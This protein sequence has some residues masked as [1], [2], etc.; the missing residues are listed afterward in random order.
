MIPSHPYQPYYCEENIRC[1]IDHPDFS[2]LETRVIFMTNRNRTCAV[3]CMKLAPPGELVIWDYHCIL[4]TLGDSPLIFDSD[5]R[6]GFGVP[7]DS[8]LAASFPLTG[9]ADLLPR[10]R[11]LEGA[12]YRAHFASDRSHMRTADGLWLQPPPPW[13]PFSSAGAS[14]LDRFLD[15]DDAFLGTVTD[16]DGLT[17]LLGG[18]NRSR[19]F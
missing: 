4:A 12:D 3:A 15:L 1:L 18:S 10:F 8:Y 11:V 9:P 14:N 7:V 2:A 5:T 19:A 16:L 17:A 13:P 6:L